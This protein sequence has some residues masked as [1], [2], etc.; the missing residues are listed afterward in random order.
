M[1][2]LVPAICGGTVLRPM[3]GP[4][5][6]MMGTIGMTLARL[7]ASGCGCGYAPVAAGTVASAIA[8]PIGAAL[9]LAS[10]ML[11]ATAALLAAIGGVWAIHAARIEGDPGWVVIDEFAG[12]WLALCGLAQVSLTGLLAAFLIFR[13]LDVTKP[14]PIG[15]ADRQGGAA[16]IMADDLIAGA[17]TAGIIWAINTHWP[18]VLS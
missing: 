14:G 4:V 16:G 5:P 8:V 18:T 7:I 3:D 11:L 17:I 10:P 13:L 9:M 12:Q 2:G 6:A 15:W 1:A